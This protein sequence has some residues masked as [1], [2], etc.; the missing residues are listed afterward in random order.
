MKE[1]ETHV[2][3]R[4]VLQR[5]QFVHQAINKSIEAVGSFRRSSECSKE[6]T[7]CEEPEEVV[8]VAESMAGDD[9][10]EPRAAGF[11]EEGKVLDGEVGL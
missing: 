4:Q 1:L 5:R 6:R 2:S 9:G 10:G 7:S 11:H 3:V 8:V